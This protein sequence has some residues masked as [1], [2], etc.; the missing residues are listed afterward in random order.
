VATRIVLSCRRDRAF[1]SKNA[2]A[3]ISCRSGPRATLPSRTSTVRQVS[4]TITASQCQLGEHNK[5]YEG[6]APHRPRARSLGRRR[7]NRPRGHEREET[8]MT[9]FELGEQGATSTNR[10]SQTGRLTA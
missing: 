3:S 10:C 4:L 5:I 6:R 7:S 2:A 1:V 8:A 9:P